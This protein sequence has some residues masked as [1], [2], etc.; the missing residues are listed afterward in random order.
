MGPAVDACGVVR[1]P[2]HNAKLLTKACQNTHIT[3]EPAC[4][5]TRSSFSAYLNRESDEINPKIVARD[6]KY[7][8]RCSIGYGAGDETFDG[9]GRSYW[10][11]LRSCKRRN[12]NRTLSLIH[13]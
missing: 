4:V 9:I 1:R 12:N 8:R 13:I 3:A 5:Y 7:L 11:V 10:P 2:L 6:T